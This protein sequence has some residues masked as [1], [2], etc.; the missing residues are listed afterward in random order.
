M[1]KVFLTIPEQIARLRGRGLE[2]PDERFAAQILEKEN[3]YHLIN[4]YKELFL[5]RSAP[6]ERYRAGTQ[7]SEFVALYE[8][9]RELRILFL[10]HILE[11]ENDVKSVLSHKFAGRYGLSGYLKIES[12][13]TGNPPGSSPDRLREV[14]ELI[15]KLQREISN[16]LS[17]NNPM[18]SHNL[19]TYGCVP[20]WVLVNSLS[21]G[22]VSN[23][24][25][26]LRERDKNEI[27]RTFSLR[28]DE[29]ESYLP[30]LAL[31]RNACAHNERLYSLKSLRRSGKPNAIKTTSVHRA[32]H[33]PE[34]QKNNPACGKNDLFAVV[35]ILKRMLRRKS[36][37]ELYAALEQLIYEAESG[38]V[39]ATKGE[40][41]AAMGFPEN[42]AE[43][44]QL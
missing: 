26:L 19:L 41:L 9:D 24:Y 4:G 31:F 39:T 3:Y 11:V 17:R 25:S 44:E 35:V 14:A 1:Q 5:D 6:C 18:I 40:L 33:L 13:D 23:F 42:W 32:L 15:T 28:P 22:I 37:S 43:I 30:M 8:F 36:F 38:F 7:F 27:G 2:I 21:F 34:R 20:L 29:M 10:R 12:F 16:Q